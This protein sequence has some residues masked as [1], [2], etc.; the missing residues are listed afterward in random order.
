MSRRVIRSIACLLGEKPVC[1]SARIKRT[2]GNVVRIESM[3]ETESVTQ[4]GRGDESSV[5]IGLSTFCSWILLGFRTYESAMIASV[6][7]RRGTVLEMPD[8]KN[9]DCHPDNG[10]CKH[11][12]N[13]YAY[14][15]KWQ[16]P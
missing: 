7:R 5:Q 14:S 10:I 13:D 4:H 2:Y 12:S 16:R 9:T 1:L 15:W 3:A 8:K 11:Q 6:R